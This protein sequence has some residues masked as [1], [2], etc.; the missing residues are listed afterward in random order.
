MIFTVAAVVVD[1]AAFVDP[2]LD[3][4]TPIIRDNLSSTARDRDS[5]ELAS[6]RVVP[7]S[8]EEIRTTVRTLI[9]SNSVD[10]ILVVGG[11]GFEAR[12]YTPEVCRVSLLGK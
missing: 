9:E 2:T 8:V 11:I 7:P 4:A 1:S 5:F 10:W 12:D 3:V 6:T